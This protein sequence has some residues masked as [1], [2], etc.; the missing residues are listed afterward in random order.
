MTYQTYKSKAV[1]ER[2]E[3]IRR[4]KKILFYSGIIRNIAV[5]GAV[6]F[7]IAVLGYVG[8]QDRQ[9]ELLNAGYTLEE[10]RAK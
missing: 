9:M 1:T 4:Q 3:R 8:E 6:L 7:F 10:A 2:A 5:I